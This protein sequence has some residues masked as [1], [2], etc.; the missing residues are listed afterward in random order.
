[1]S[2]WDSTVVLEGVWG[3]SIGNRWVGHCCVVRRVRHLVTDACGATPTRDWGAC[4]GAPHVPVQ[5]G[6]R[7]AQHSNAQPNSATLHPGLHWVRARDA[8]TW[9]VLFPTD[10]PTHPRCTARSRTAAPGCAYGAAAMCQP[11]L[12]P[13]HSLTKP[14]TNTHNNINTPAH[15]THIST[16]PPTRGAPLGVE[17]QLGVVLLL[18]VPPP[19]QG[20]GGGGGDGERR[21]VAGCSGR[22]SEGGECGDVW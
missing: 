16:H 22:E 21:H 5:S 17:Q 9:P 20:A 4:G 13:A 6:A 3:G 15:H 18:L 14:H 11:S 12:N 10:P 8:F 19:H 7:S 1:M 2:W